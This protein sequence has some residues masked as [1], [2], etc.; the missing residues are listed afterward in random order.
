MDRTT[1]IFGKHSGSS[2]LNNF[3]KK[4]GLEVEKTQLELLLEKIEQLSTFNKKPVTES[5]ILSLYYQ[6]PALTKD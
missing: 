4:Q 5:D 1:F 3:F 2:S 6:L